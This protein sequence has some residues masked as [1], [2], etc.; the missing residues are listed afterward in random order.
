MVHISAD[1]HSIRVQCAL[2]IY[3]LMSCVCAQFCVMYRKSAWFSISLLQIMPIGAQEWRLRTGLIN[4]SRTLRVIHTRSWSPLSCHCSL[5]SPSWR[6]WRALLLLLTAPLACR[7]ATAVMI[8]VGEGGGRESK[9][10]IS[11]LLLSFVWDLWMFLYRP[12]AVTSHFM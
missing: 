3:L 10:T 11:L 1:K 6:G 8:L 4:A 12:L 9:Y 2:A 5:P 7:I